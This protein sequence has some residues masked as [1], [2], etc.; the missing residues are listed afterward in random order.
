M[1][2]QKYI[3]GIMGVLARE[4]LSLGS[5]ESELSQRAAGKGDI[6]IKRSGQC[7]HECTSN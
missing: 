7:H 3:E 5:K 1:T 4:A 2:E 6:P